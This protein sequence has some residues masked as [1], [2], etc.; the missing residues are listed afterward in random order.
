[1]TNVFRPS[2]WGEGKRGRS[3]AKR[4]EEACLRFIQAERNIKVILIRNN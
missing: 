1:M 4:Q 3:E 2:G